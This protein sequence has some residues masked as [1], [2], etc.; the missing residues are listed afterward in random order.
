MLIAEAIRNAQKITGKKVVNGEDVR[1]GL[2]ALNITEARLK[3]LGMEGFAAPMKLSCEDHNGHHR[4]FVAEWDGTKWVKVSDRI[5]PMTDK[6]RP[7]IEAAAKDYAEK[8]T[9]WPKRIGELRQAVVEACHPGRAAGASRDAMPSARRRGGGSRL[10]ARAAAGMTSPLWARGLEPACPP[11]S[12]RN[13]PEPRPPRPS[14][15]STTSR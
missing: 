3:E 6:V 9:G 10:S 2:E 14:S 4:R 12:P 13:R 7:L 5:E 15:R 11:P 8:N 1:R